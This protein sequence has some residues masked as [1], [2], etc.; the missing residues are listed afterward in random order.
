M[1]NKFQTILIVVFVAVALISTL[2]FAGILPG[3]KGGGKGK[4]K[5]E[6]LAMWGVFDEAK[7][8]L[9]VSD[10]NDKNRETFII[11]YKQKQKD[12][13]ESDLV[14]ALAAG[15]GPDMWVISQDAILKSK[16]KVFLIPFGTFSERGFND[17][18]TDASSVYLTSLADAG[19]NSREIRDAG[20]GIVGI[21][22]AIDPIVLYWNKDLFSSAGVAKPP[23]SW[24][25][26]LVSVR[27]LTKRDNAG[28][29]TQSGVALGEFNN[30][31]NAKDILSMMVLQ[32]G[33]KIIDPISMKV[34]FGK[35]ENA[36]I[37]NPVENAV[38]FFNEFSNPQKTSYSWN[39]VLPNSKDMFASGSLAMYFGYA[40][41]FEG[42]K[43]K[44]PHLKFDIAV[45]PQSKKGDIKATFG[46]IYSIVISRTSLKIAAAFPA[47]S[48]LTMQGDFTK[49]FSE[50]FLLAPPTRNLLSAGSD[51]P[52]L[53]I[54]Y[55]SA[56]MAR[57]WLEPDP[58]EI[59]KIFKNMVESTATGKL[60]I[61]EA[62]RK[63]KK[64]IEQLIKTR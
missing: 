3:F 38:L 9:L 37:I 39:R 60:R 4:G 28:N 35:K 64:E 61:S 10:I 25:E 27:A 46:K 42:I 51:N 33:N 23:E 55:Q 5:V 13:Y 48:Q 30:I 44:N 6:N 54:I 22:M 50:S 2:I 43:K 21:P 49:G 62:V 56:I 34:V 63:A 11:K 40:S 52:A 58:E 41:E 19:M 31:K 14:N 20:R 15:K 59:N 1:K 8:R 47:I 24:E 53:S 26:F 16:D 29:I 18:F 12:S 57:T 17:A 36:E 32:L 7:M 45:V